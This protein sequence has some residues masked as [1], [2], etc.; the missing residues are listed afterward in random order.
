M[1]LRDILEVE[2]GV[3][4]IL[5]EGRS[6]EAR[7]VSQGDDYA[8]EIEGKRLP[9]Q[10][11]DPRNFDR[12]SRSGVGHGKQSLAALMPGKI[13]RVLVEE[14]QHV[15][16]GQGLVVVEAMKMQN[17]MKAA[18]GGTVTKIRARDGMT[19]VASEVLMVIE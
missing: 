9:V 10:I 14:G 15:E 8:V 6:Y 3:Y 4:S 11:R 13:I 5:L 18:R 1:K 17:E 7:V 19:V 2:P 12:T 16:P